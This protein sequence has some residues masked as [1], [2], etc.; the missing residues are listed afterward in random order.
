M[1]L[2][3]TA[4]LSAYIAILCVETPGVQGKLRAFFE[5]SASWRGNLN[6][7]EIPPGE[8]YAK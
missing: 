8:K 7:P 5:E 2:V 3:G 1:K 4:P 6:E